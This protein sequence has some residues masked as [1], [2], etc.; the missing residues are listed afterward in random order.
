[1]PARSRQSSVPGRAA[2]SAVG[3]GLHLRLDLARLGLSAFVIDVFSRRIVGW[4]QSSSMHTD[5]V[6]DALEQA[7]YDHKPC[8]NDG[9]IHHSDRARNT[10]RS[11]TANDWPRP[12]SSLQW[13]PRVIAM[14]TPWQDNQRLYRPKS[15][16]DVVHGGPNGP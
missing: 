6:L 14:T 9:L 2:Q 5:F 8:E 1:M 10:C 12:G 3:L 4:R 15:S 13:A 11:A 16:I 7:L